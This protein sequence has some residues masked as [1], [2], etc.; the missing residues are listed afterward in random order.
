MLLERVEK[1]VKYKLITLLMVDAGLR[2]SEAVSLKI[3]NFIF[4]EKLIRVK[5][6]K[7][8]KEQYRDVPMSSRLIE[9]LAKY[10]GKMKGDKDKET[11]LFSG[12]NDHLKRVAVW[13]F[14]NR[15][16][17]KCPQLAHVHPH[18]LRHTFATR[19][20]NSDVSLITARELLG[21]SSVQTT[22]IYT[23]IPGEILKNSIEKIEPKR[24]WLVSVGDW[25]VG[26]KRVQVIRL[27]NERLQSILIGRE[28][29]LAKLHDLTD[30]LVNVLI[31]GCQG[32]G[33]SQILDNLKVDD[34]KIV[35]LDEVKNVRIALVNFALHVL[36]NDKSELMQMLYADTD[37]E[38]KISKDSTKNLVDLL[39]RITEIGEY[40]MIVDD[41]SDITPTGVKVLEQLR[42]HMHIICA[43]R[44]VKIDK[45]GFLTNFEIIDIKNLSRAESLEL[46]HRLSYDVMSSIEDYE[47]YKNHI[48]E[49]TNGN[50]QYIY[51]LIERYRKEE[52]IANE[53]VR[54]IR[55]TAANKEIDFTPILLVCLASLIVLKYY[56]REM[57]EDGYQLI[58]GIALVFALFARQFFRAF[59]RKFI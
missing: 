11:Y 51:E 9:T 40:T 32:V 46:I 43:A 39:K 17:K 37:V 52:Y 58:G 12:I 48:W 10:L 30:K 19:L 53:T 27:G 25:L 2:V 59:K 33:K 49:Q 14:Y 22:E 24:S 4:R 42:N 55:H 44:A 20:V 56:G 26:K 31:R 57:D 50:P 1:N 29:E 23:H 7:K 47:L 35:R 41:V 13:R 36:K 15:I 28:V 38:V 21:H 3:R 6:L 16:A 5:S 34:R 18:A 45:A 8:K 54:E